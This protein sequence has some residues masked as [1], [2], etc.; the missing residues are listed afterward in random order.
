M[1]RLTALLIGISIFAV[2]CDNKPDNKR[3][4]DGAGTPGDSNSLSPDA[5]FDVPSNQ[6]D[7]KEVRATNRPPV[8]SDPRVRILDG[9]IVVN[10]LS[11][12][13]PADWNRIATA[14][15]VQ[16]ARFAAPPAQGE[17]AAATTVAFFDPKSES[18]K[19][20]ADQVIEHCAS[21][22]D[23]GVAESVIAKATVRKRDIS[24]V[25]VTTFDYTG[26][27]AGG[28]VQRQ[29]GATVRS[30][31]RML[32]AFF[33]HAGQ[34]VHL[35]ALGPAKSISAL[36]PGFQ[37]MVSGVRP[38]DNAARQTPAAANE[39]PAKPDQ[40]AGMMSNRGAVEVQKNEPTAH[41]EADTSDA[42][43]GDDMEI[44]GR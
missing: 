23:D 18:D 42:S 5:P 1:S 27:Y 38:M 11:F 25:T 21:Q 31:Y 44:P 22:F 20:I 26:D 14:A 17:R 37:S 29:R 43:T 30:D 36:E 33:E 2:G 40:P 32:S 12:E 9:R 10:T 13:A 34:T 6:L 41:Q 28:P 16:L 35:R 4:S 24:G 39:T 7:R 19:P 3:S 8:I 15:R